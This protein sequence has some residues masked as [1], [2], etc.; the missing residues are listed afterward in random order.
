MIL[1]CLIVSL[2]SVNYHRIVSATVH[3]YLNSNKSRVGEGQLVQVVN[4]NCTNLTFNLFSAHNFEELIMYPDG[5]CKDAK[6]SQRK[7][8]IHFSKCTC[9]VGF[10]VKAV[11]SRINCICECDSK[12]A[13]YITDCDHQTQ[14]LTRRDDVWI[15]YINTTNITFGGYLTHLHCPLDYCKP[16]NSRVDIKL[17]SMNGADAQCANNRT[18]LL[19]GSCKPIFSLSL[20]SSTCLTCS[21]YWPVLSVVIV[22]FSVLAGI[23][24][25]TFL[26]ILD[27]TVAVR[28]LNG[29]IFYAN[30]VA[31]SSSTFLPFSRPTFATVF[32]SWLNLEL[33]LNVCFFQGMDA[34]WKTWLQL[35]FPLYLILLVIAIIYVSHWS[36]RFS[37]LIGKKNPVAT[38]ATLILLSYAKLLHTIIAA[39]SNAVLIYP[40][41]DGGQRKDVWLLDASIGYLSGR[42]IPVFIVA[43]LILLIGVTYTTLLFA[44]QWLVHFSEMKILKVIRNQKLT[45]FIATYHAPYNPQNRYWTGLLLLVRVILYVA[46]AANIPGD[47]KVNVLLVGIA[48]VCI[49]L[50]KEVAAVKSR[51][52]KKWPIELLEVSCFVNLALLCLGTFFT[53]D[54]KAANTAVANTSVSITFIIFPGILSY[55]LFS[56]ITARISHHK[57]QHNDSD[58]QCEP[59]SCSTETSSFAPTS[60]V[61]EAPKKTG[62]VLGFELR[63]PLLEQ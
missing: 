58:D 11:D 6:L 19:C 4:E 12:L 18:G 34:Y 2:T 37:L 5:P 33:G 15:S 30:I 54:N 61:I 28:T 47:P 16:S 36:K 63:E 39:F 38:L 32:I 17:N 29:I 10:Q 1:E 40:S 20:G 27:L 13:K 3:S 8:E 45:L 22:L 56:E 9:P 42:H 46:S 24:L 53:L 35:L 31:A 50:F 51:V 48:T 26:L 41:L 7:I 14:T 49:L 25:V 57:R 62:S 52:Y 59:L 23:V 21:A 55:H 43:I 44:W 60:S